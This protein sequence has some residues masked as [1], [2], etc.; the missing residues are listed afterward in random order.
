MAMLIDAIRFR[1]F[2]NYLGISY[3]VL[4][5]LFLSIQ[6]EYR[7]DHPAKHRNRRRLATNRLTYNNPA[8]LGQ[9]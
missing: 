4:G 1:F 8:W 5:F 7:Y 6:Y 9:T 2:T 3:Y